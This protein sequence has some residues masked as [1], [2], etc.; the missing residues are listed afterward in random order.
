MSLKRLD[1]YNVRNIR[2]QS[3]LPATTF[4]F[5]YGKNGS[6]KSALI[7]AIFLLGRAKSFRSSSIKPVISFNQP[8]LI[9]SADILKDKQRTIHM[10]IRMDGNETEI[11]INHLQNQKRISLAYGLPLQIIHPK[12]FELLDA[13]SKIRREFLDWGIFNHDERFLD[14]WRK[15]KQALLQ[16]NAL[17]KLKSINQLN[18]WNNELVNYGTIVNESRSEYLTALKKVLNKSINYF[19]NFDDFDITLMSG[20]SMDKGLRQDLNDNLEKDL[21]YGFTHSGPHRGD[22]HFLIKKKF[23]KDVVSRGQLKLLILCLKLAQVELILK[24]RKDFGCILIDDLAAELD[25]ENRLKV[26]QYLS[27][28]QC[29]AFITTTELND[30]GDLSFI[31]NYKL[32]HVEHGEIESKYVS[33]G[34]SI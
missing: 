1:I 27:Q 13:S 19:L 23:A 33:H 29:Q 16:R 21:R 9:V 10:G 32:F 18:V 8:D 26:L 14:S 7:E 4:N 5:I 20:W 6:G 2:E 3:I 11:R 24:E 22:F 34:T 30:F 25:R 28:I 31:D 15:Y 17:L 12:S